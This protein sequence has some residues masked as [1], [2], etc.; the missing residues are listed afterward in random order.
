MGP[1]DCIQCAGDEFQPCTTQWYCASNAYLQ[2][3]QQ[4]YTEPLPWQAQ[5]RDQQRNRILKNVT[6]TMEGLIG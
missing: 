2:F 4:N 6:E 3:E 1:L 5:L